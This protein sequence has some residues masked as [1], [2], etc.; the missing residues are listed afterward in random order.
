MKTSCYLLLNAI[1]SVL[2]IMT[3]TVLVAAW[4]PV[5]YDNV[6]HFWLGKASAWAVVALPTNNFAAMA[7]FSATAA[8]LAACVG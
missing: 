2:T 4:R 3:T 7:N 6:G 8:K 5:Q 1:L